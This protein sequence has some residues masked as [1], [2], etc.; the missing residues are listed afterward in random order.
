[1]NFYYVVVVKFLVVFRKICGI[2]FYSIVF[3]CCGTTSSHSEYFCFV[4]SRSIQ[5][6]IWFFSPLI[7]NILH[8]R[9][10]SDTQFV[11]FFIVFTLYTLIVC[12][13]LSLA[14]HHLGECNNSEYFEWTAVKVSQCF[15]FC[16]FRSSVSLF[17][18]AFVMP[19]S[20]RFRVHI[21]THTVQ[22]KS[23]WRRHLLPYT[24][25][26]TTARIHF[27]DYFVAR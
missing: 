6:H 26:T 5:S 1:M 19:H 22:T 15:Y 23:W 27:S 13:F 20:S 25:V 17:I 9:K 16:F 14:P 18:N 4:P 3:V 11:F 10:I 24:R 7:Y 12:V 21:Y 2:F 8:L